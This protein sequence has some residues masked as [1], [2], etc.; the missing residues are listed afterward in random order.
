MAFLR[1]DF[2]PLWG[3]TQRASPQTDMGE[4]PGPWSLGPDCSWG[5]TRPTLSVS[6]SHTGHTDIRG[7]SWG[8]GIEEDRKYVGIFSPSHEAAL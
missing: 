8:E 2:S 4:S 5:L 3:E 6:D 1:V 7:G